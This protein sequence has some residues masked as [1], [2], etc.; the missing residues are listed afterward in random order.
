MDTDAGAYADGLLLVDK[1]GGM[2]SHDV[3]AAVR[4]LVRPL[5]VGHTGTLD[6][7]AT[8]LL[9]LCIG[10]A[11]KIAGFIE[12]QS[13]V[14]HAVALL[15]TETDTL[16]LTGRII[17]QTSTEEISEDS[18]REAA[19]SFVGEVDQV[20]PAFSA[21]KVDGVRAYALARRGENVPL[22][23]RKVE[24]RR[25][26]IEEVRLPRIT[27]LLECS[28][29]TYVRALCRDLGSALG[30][31]GCME[32]LRRL[33][34]GDF[35]ISDAVPLDRLDKKE[36]VLEALAPTSKAL[37]HLPVLHCTAEQAG[38]IAHG[39]QLAVGERIACSADDASW[40]QALG[41]DGGLIAVG[42]LSREGETVLFHP[43]RVLLRHRECSKQA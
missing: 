18:I 35:N 24:I 38:Q 11:T 33:A 28:K 7:V 43:K 22:K 12:T 5:R 41:P 25:L 36:K 26:E 3:V 19:R 16:D 20:P 27:F 17:R 14:Y 4:K 29:G 6:P 8:G 21:I 34:V 42:K 37:P 30:V 39:M 9:V 1:P 13:K 23:P 2:T 32:S 15:G 10:E 40:A 31:G